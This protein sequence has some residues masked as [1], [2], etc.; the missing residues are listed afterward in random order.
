M[1][2]EQVKQEEKFTFL[3]M[4]QV[5]T[6]TAKAFVDLANKEFSGHFGFCLKAL[7]DQLIIQQQV[8]SEVRMDEFDDRL[9]F[10][11]QSLKYKGIDEQESKPKR[12]RVG[13]EI[14]NG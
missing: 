1:A 2:D 13:G 5:P 9:R 4:K 3:Y 12:K 6:E 7:L 8:V 14:E 10:L 11:E